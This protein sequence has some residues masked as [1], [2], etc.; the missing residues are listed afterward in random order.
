MMQRH[1]VMVQRRERTYTA[2]GFAYRNVGTPV[3]LQCNFRNIDTGEVGANGVVVTYNAR[4]LTTSPWP[5]G[6]TD[7][8]SL[9]RIRGLE[10]DMAGIP[11]LRDGSA[12]TAHLQ[13]N[14]NYVGPD[15]G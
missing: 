3:P 7:T 11:L 14:L 8:S 15:S 12:R 13:V 10:Y 1:T 4:L 6:P 5:G 2:H 9:V